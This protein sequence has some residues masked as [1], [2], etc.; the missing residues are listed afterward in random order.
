MT[1]LTQPMCRAQLQIIFDGRGAPNSK[2]LLVEVQPKSATVSR[3]GYHE[4]DTWSLEFDAR[5]VPFDV[6]GIAAIAVRIYMWDGLLA[7]PESEWA[8][9]ANEMIR[10]L[11]DEPEFEFVG[12]QTISLSGRDYTAALDHEWD[13]RDKIKAGGELTE[14]VQSIADEAIPEGSVARFLV[15]WM[16]DE[17]V[18]HCFGNTRSTKKK[19]AWVK[20]GKTTWEVIYDLVLGHGFIC[21]VEDSRI[22]IA[23]PAFQTK[24]NLALTTQLVHGRDLS[25][26]KISRKLA[27]ERVPQ[28]KIVYWDAKGRQKFSVTYPEKGRPPT[29]GV[30]FK[31]DESEV[32]PAPSYCHDRDSALRFAKMRYELIARGES[33]YTFSTRAMRVPIQPEISEIF[34]DQADLDVSNERSLLNIH[35]GDAISIV[36]DPF[37]REHMRTQSPAQRYEH[38]REMGYSDSVSQFVSQNM[39]RIDQFRQPYYVRTISFDWSSSDGLKIE[40]EG[41]NYATERREVAWAEGRLPDENND[42]DQIEIL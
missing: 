2:A 4:A 5:L 23:D 42:Q 31:K 17:P 35:A 40:G 27:K 34:R 13:P 10:G 15:E 39:E 26:L 28:M 14:V 22:I 21:Y 16:S 32:I 18:P 8:V 19:G 6:D 1:R 37:N 30:G 3:N 12:S 38:M 41:V 20:P 29:I 36:F 33:T 24:E 7:G 25:S 11:A 9:E